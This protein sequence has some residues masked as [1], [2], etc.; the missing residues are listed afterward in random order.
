MVEIMQDVS[1]QES[2][3]QAAGRVAFQAESALFR[4]LVEARIK[5]DARFGDKEPSQLFQGSIW[6][7]TRAKLALPFPDFLVHRLHAGVRS[8]DQL[9]RFRNA[10]AAGEWV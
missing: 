1:A 7:C 10:A 3:F 4:E 9:R 5:S 8:Q 6:V 2:R